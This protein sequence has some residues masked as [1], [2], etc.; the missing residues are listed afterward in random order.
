MKRAVIF[1]FF[2]FGF[3]VFGTTQN[4][5]LFNEEE[6]HLLNQKDSIIKVDGKNSI[7]Y[8]I[9]LTSI[10]DCYK[11]NNQTEK[12]IAAF[13][14]IKD[15][16]ATTSFKGNS[17]EY[18]KALRSLAAKYRINISELSLVELF[19]KKALTI[20]QKDMNKNY[21]DYIKSLWDL[22][23]I[24]ID[25]GDDDKAEILLLDINKITEANEGKNNND[26][27]RTLFYL[28][29]FYKTRRLDYKLTE[30]YYMEILEIAK[31]FSGKEQ[32]IYM[33]TLATVGRY[34]L[35]RKN[36]EQSL[37]YLLMAKDY[38]Q[39]NSSN[40]KYAD[41]T[42]TL[43]NLSSLYQ[44]MSDSKKA[45]EYM[46]ESLLTAKDSATGANEYLKCLQSAV[47]FYLVTIKDSLK[48]EKYLK[49]MIAVCEKKINNTNFSYYCGAAQR[50][51]NLLEIKGDI[52]AAEKYYLKPINITTIEKTKYANYIKNL[53]S[54]A[55]L[56]KNTGNTSRAEYYFLQWKEAY[57]PSS[58]F[59]D[60]YV[61]MMFDLALFNLSI[62][63]YD[64]ALDAEKEA[65]QT[66]RMQVQRAFSFYSNNRRSEYWEKIAPKL[67]I[68]YSLSLYLPQKS[69]ILS[70]DNTLFSK[71][72]LLRT[73]NS[74]KDAIMVSGDSI[75]I[76]NYNQL[77]NM[78]LRNTELQKNS[79]PDDEEEIKSLE[80][81]V[82]NL[83]RLLTIASTAFSDLKADMAMTWLDV[84]KQLKP[85]EA[86]V[87]FVSFRLYNKNWTDSTMY[88]A[89]VLRPDMTAPV[90]IPLFEQ[91]Q[92]DTLLQ[93]S[94]NDVQLQTENLY[95]D[96]GEKIYQLVWQA[97]EKELSNMKTI[98]YSPSGLLHK[99][100]FNA[101][102]TE[103]ENALLSDK[104]NLYLVSSTREVAQLKKEAAAAAVQ[105]STVVYGGLLYDARQQEM[106]AAAK[107]YQQQ[108]KASAVSAKSYMGGMQK[109]DAE[110]PD[111]TLRGGF[112]EWK[113][114]AG[115]K[116]E[117]E[118]IVSEL[119]QKRIPTEYYTGN[120]G[121]EESFKHL[122]GTKT[123][124]IHLSTHGF[125][126]PDIE[127]KAVEDIV[128]RL[129]GAK[130][131]PFENSLLR[132]GLIMSGANN[133]WLA[134]EY[135]MQDGVEDGILTADEISRLNLINT[136]LV[137]LSACETGLG[138]VKNS[139]GVFGLQRAFKLAGVESLIMSLWKVPDDATSELMTNFYHQWLSGQTK[140]NAFKAAQQK[141]REKYK[142]PYYWAAFV[143]MD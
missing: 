40:V 90:W 92:L 106:Q 59:K 85:A 71:G 51:G 66:I 7:E 39:I 52:A 22:S 108:D 47:N 133:Q 56:Y 103:K 24:Y 141:V 101:L 45:E 126:L 32:A 127:N 68:P 87:E 67:E 124:V 110:L 80:K 63:K 78:R 15:V 58:K 74:V 38:Y 89:L 99:I 112:S 53:E 25:M 23:T 118:E 35:D 16:L 50:L 77:L 6:N 107:P 131:K 137:V 93:T 91:K 84:Q 46:Q 105:D 76:S 140:Q 83:E 72:L 134:K 33:N 117:T 49:E 44:L 27:V 42:K 4:A 60:D 43:L 28:V 18:V 136:K 26:Y 121:N 122:S 12:T 135:I 13:N 2:F 1:L 123:G 81:S 139:E 95:N 98:Y 19:F 125:F 86:A 132:S 31:D 115:T 3:Y 55:Q 109:R 96:K 9:L 21:K 82:S 114:L 69:T 64:D 129:G 116:K 128:Q 75:L 11:S 113:Y 57:P 138:D 61:D 10:Y 20:T 62:G 17:A 34:F 65:S 100:A 79:N 102:P 5:K 41:Y 120:A 143:M 73:E 111:S 36:F 37:K 142:S 94:D 54:I 97:L 30:R 14:E 8:L 29:N 119:K 88:A 104:Y 48:A 130:E 70:Y